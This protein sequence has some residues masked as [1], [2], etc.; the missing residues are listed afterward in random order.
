MRTLR[1]RLSYDSLDALE[2]A[3]NEYAGQLSSKA[4]EGAYIAAESAVPTAIGACPSSRVAA[5]IEAVR[6]DGG[7]S[8]VANG[9]ML[10]P[11]DGGY[12]VPLS[13]ILE[14]GSGARGDAAYGAENGYTVDM[15]GKGEPG[16]R[17]PKGDGSFGFTHGHVASRYMA[18]AA[19][20]A[21]A[22]IADSM[23]EAFSR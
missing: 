7:A 3:L 11:E 10:S 4:E 22:N 5:T 1:A 21:R 13:Q 18:Q 17:Y 16:W 6:E 20:E 15:S 14:F 2:A 19:E 8:V 9:P 12:E 23:R